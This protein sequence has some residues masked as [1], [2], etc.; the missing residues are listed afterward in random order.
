MRK[1]TLFLCAMMV[2]SVLV[3]QSESNPKL[4][5]SS[6]DYSWNT[7]NRSRAMVFYDGKLYLPDNNLANSAVHVIDAATGIEDD[8]ATIVNEDFQSFGIA[9]DN[10][11]HLLL[12]KNTGGLA[13]WILSKV[14]IA[15]GEVTTLNNGTPISGYRTDYIAI[16]GDIENTEEPA[17][18]IGAST[19]NPQIQAWEFLSGDLTETAPFV[20]VRPTTAVAADIKWIDDT[21]ALLTQQ[22]RS[23]VIMTVDFTNPSEF[24][25]EYEEINITGTTIGGGAYFEL[26]DTPYIVIPFGSSAQYGAVGIFDIS[27]IENP[28]EIGEPTEAIGSTANGAAHLGIEAI[29]VDDEN[30]IIYVWSPNNGAAAYE[31]TTPTGEVGI[32]GFAPQA[33]IRVKRTAEGIEIPLNAVSTVELYTVSGMLIDKAVV[34]GNYTRELTPG[35]YIVRVNGQAVKVVK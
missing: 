4:L 11:G 8:E 14:D 22:S 13:P 23:P 5:W 29:K 15:S 10:A 1:I 6:T 28:V 7:G 26:E 25:A 24:I 2:S 19:N 30:V 18:A 33:G 20:W 9:V 35:M 27:D 17:Y 31:F 34:N 3:A 21:Q 16:L 12:P 32:K